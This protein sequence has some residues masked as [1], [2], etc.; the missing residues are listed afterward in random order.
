MEK[1]PVVDMKNLNTEDK[2]STMEI[3]K[4][5]CENWG[6]FEVYSIMLCWPHIYICILISTFFII[7]KMFVSGIEFRIRNLC[8]KLIQ[9]RLVHQPNYLCKTY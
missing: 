8:L 4:D 7:D 3:I 2:A 5:A 6:F 9:C 1:F